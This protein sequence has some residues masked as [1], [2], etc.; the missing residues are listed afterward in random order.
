M[1]RHNCDTHPTL[2]RVALMALR[3][4]V[5]FRKRKHAGHWKKLNIEKAKKEGT[6]V[7]DKNF[8][9]IDHRS[10]ERIK[11]KTMN[12]KEAFLKNKA[13]EGTGFS[14]NQIDADFNI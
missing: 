14:W 7:Q 6:H 11:T 2:D 3:E 1:K 8:V 4:H 10:G 5:A 12:K 9:L 13:I